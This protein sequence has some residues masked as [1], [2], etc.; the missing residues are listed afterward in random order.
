MAEHVESV[1]PQEIDP[2][3]AKIVTLARSSR[4]RTGAA[5]GAAVRDTDGRTYAACTVALPSLRLTALQAAVAAAVASG[6]EGL[7]AAAVVTDAD[8]VDAD[9]AAAVRDLTSTATILRADARG[10]VVAVLQA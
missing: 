8:S 6:A 10:D 4:A 3:D 5:E 7:E 1:A 9:S 2:E